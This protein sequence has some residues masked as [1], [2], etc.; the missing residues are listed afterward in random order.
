[1]AWINCRIDGRTGKIKYIGSHRI[2]NSKRVTPCTAAIVIPRD[3]EENISS[4][5]SL[6]FGPAYDD[7]HGCVA[8]FVASLD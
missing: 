3:L 4:V 1:M 8:P 6:Y 7:L 5:W 2:F